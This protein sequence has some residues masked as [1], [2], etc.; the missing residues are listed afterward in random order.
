MKLRKHTWS[1]GFLLVALILSGCNIG[2][3]PAPTQDVAAIQSTAIAQAMAALSGQ[4][5]Q[6][7]AAI[8]PTA[9]PTNTLVPTITIQPTIDFANFSSPTP[10]ANF[11]PLAGIPTVTPGVISTITTKNGCNDGTYIGETKPFDYDEV[12]IGEKIAKGW[13]ILNTGTCDWDEGYV[14]QFLADQSDPEIKGTSIILHKNRPDEYTKVGHSQTYIVK[15]NAPKTAGVYKGY[16]KLKDDG[17]NFFG[18]LVSIIITVRK[19]K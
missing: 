5:T 4:Q 11:T 19:P 12:G 6:T 1:V 18:P 17:G 13:T 14:F 2:A 15:F 3:T 10:L 9:L 7:A 8:P 16:W